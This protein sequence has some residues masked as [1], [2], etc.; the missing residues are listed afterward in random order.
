MSGSQNNYDE[1][2]FV[3][4]SLASFFEPKPLILNHSAYSDEVARVFANITQTNN[5]LAIRTTIDDVSNLELP[6]NQNLIALIL[7]DDTKIN[8]DKNSQVSFN[9]FFEPTNNPS[10]TITLSS[11]KIIF[12]PYKDTLKNDLGWKVVA[13]TSRDLQQIDIGFIYG[14][15]LDNSLVISASENNLEV[16]NQIIQKN[17]PVVEKFFDFK[18][19]LYLILLI[20]VLITFF[21]RP[22]KTKGILD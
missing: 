4:I 7:R 19:I 13:I 8:L 20:I 18:Y 9:L 1:H 10:K 2:Q 3:D 17:Q 5:Q 6:A 15:V 12:Y 16:D 21:A 14:N 22:S 11:D